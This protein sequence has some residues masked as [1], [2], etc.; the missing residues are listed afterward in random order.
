MLPSADFPQSI[1]CRINSLPFASTESLEF[2]ATVSRKFSSVHSVSRFEG[3]NNWI[4]C[5]S[6][7]N[8]NFLCLIPVIWSWITCEIRSNRRARVRKTTHFAFEQMLDTNP[9][10]AADPVNLLNIL[11]ITS[12]R[13]ADIVPPPTLFL[14]R[15]RNPPSAVRKKPI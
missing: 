15:S 3:G 10:I 7:S 5:C 14:C 11:L 6:A 13:R 2:L 9:C 12:P 1:V 4:R 8:C